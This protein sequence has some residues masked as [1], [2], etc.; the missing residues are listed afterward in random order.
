MGPHYSATYFH[1]RDTHDDCVWVSA[2][3]Q[4]D[5]TRFYLPAWDRVSKRGK[6]KTAF[7]LSEWLLC[8]FLPATH[9]SSSFICK[10]T[11]VEEILLFSYSLIQSK[12][13]SVNFSTVLLRSLRRPPAFYW[14][15]LNL[16]LAQLTITRCYLLHR[17]L[18]RSEKYLMCIYQGIEKSRKVLPS[19]AR[20]RALFAT[21]LS[22][23][24]KDFPQFALPVCPHRCLNIQSSC[25]EWSQ[26]HLHHTTREKYHT[27][28][29]VNLGSW[30]VSLACR[31]N[32]Q[33]T[34]TQ[35]WME[36]Q[37]VAPVNDLSSR[38]L[39]PAGGRAQ[40]SGART[41]TDGCGS[42]CSDFIIYT[43]R[44]NVNHSK[45]VW[46]LI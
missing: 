10:Q 29:S 42:T 36:L 2:C 8:A 9:L 45:Q 21:M 30:A 12:E 38:T 1:T 6:E 37:V 32:L 24:M 27:V 40:E 44:W 22:I 4:H 34:V 18:R 46:W 31:P 33:S 14:P 19:L 41:Q 17:C 15:Q 25:A 28:E 16:H 43:Q 26:I 23:S 20:T 3:D 13:K 35:S 39:P 5:G 11:V 7:F